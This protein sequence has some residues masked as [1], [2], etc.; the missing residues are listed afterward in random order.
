LKSLTKQKS[1]TNLNLWRRFSRKNPDKGLGDIQNPDK[2]SDNIQNPD[3][4]LDD[5]QNLDKGV[6]DIQ[7]PD[8]ELDD[9]Q[10]NLEENMDAPNSPWRL[11]SEPTVSFQENIGKY[12]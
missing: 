9:I 8:K 2:G 10:S 4:G 3:K 11:K 6:G 7:N 5:I 12:F 1:S